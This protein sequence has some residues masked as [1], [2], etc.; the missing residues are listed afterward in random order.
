MYVQ[1]KSSFLLNASNL[2][3][4]GSVASRPT[5]TKAFLKLKNMVPIPIVFMTLFLSKQ[6]ANPSRNQRYNN[7][8][9]DLNSVR[10]P[11]V[12][13]EMRPIDRFHLGVIMLKEV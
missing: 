6:C 5:K 2:S 7:R 1:T 10:F 4:L 8:Q 12:T 11:V 13:E 9:H 3:S